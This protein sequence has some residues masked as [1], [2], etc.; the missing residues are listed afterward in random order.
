MG[1]RVIRSLT[2]DPF[3]GFTENALMLASGGRSR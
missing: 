3:L 1:N 2:F